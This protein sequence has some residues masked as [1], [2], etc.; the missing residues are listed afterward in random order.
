MP[1][2]PLA[3]VKV[4]GSLRGARGGLDVDAAAKLI[5][6][7]ILLPDA[8]ISSVRLYLNGRPAGSAAI[9]HNQ[10]IADAYPKI[11]HAGRSGFRLG[12]KPHQLR[13]TGISRASVLGFQDGRAIARLDTL[14]F[15]QRLVHCAAPGGSSCH[16][17]GH[18]AGDAG[19][20]Q[21]VRGERPT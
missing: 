3:D 1:P 12:L 5:T 2:V 17:Q 10:D 11:P 4:P 9:E 19:D 15:P 21:C 20:P 14:L 18:A 6:G 7:Y 8:E 16:S 13:K